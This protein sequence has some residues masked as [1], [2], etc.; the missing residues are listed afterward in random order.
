[1]HITELSYPILTHSG[2]GYDYG[3]RG[4]GPQGEMCIMPFSYGLKIQIAKKLCLYITLNPGQEGVTNANVA[5]MFLT[6]L[7]EQSISASLENRHCVVT[8][9]KQTEER[10]RSHPKLCLKQ[11]PVHIVWKTFVWLYLYSD[12]TSARKRFAL[13]IRR[14]KFD[15]E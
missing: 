15:F 1:M 11:V 14:S 13:L 10:N 9:A 8:T 6:L 4:R 7:C 12:S 5:K 2:R 3:G